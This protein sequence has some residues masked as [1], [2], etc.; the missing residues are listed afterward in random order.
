MGANKQSTMRGWCHLGERRNK[1]REKGETV[2]GGMRERK[3]GD[4]GK[5]N[6]RDRRSERK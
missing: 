6:E 5:E 1:E 3:G 4:G 2:G